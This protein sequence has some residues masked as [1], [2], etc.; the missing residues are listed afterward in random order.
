MNQ[1][2]I[3]EYID[4]GKFVST[5]CIQDKGNR[6]LLLTP[7]NR[8]VNIPPKRAVLI[9]GPTVDV[10]R[11]R[12]DL[13]EK[14]RLSEEFR[15][16]LKERIDVQE[17]WEL[18]NDENES[19]NLKYLAQ[20]AFGEA[21]TEDHFSALVRALFEDRLYFKMKDGLFRPNSKERVDQIARQREEAALKEERL[22][23]GSVWLNAVWQDRKAEEPSCKKNIIDTLVQLALHGNESSDYKYGK[24]LLS[25]AGIS[26]V[27]NSKNLLVKIGIWTEDENLEILRSGIATSFT[28]EQVEESARM[29]SEKRS[30]EGCEDLRDLPVMT[31]DGPHTSDFDDALSFEMAGD[32]FEIGVHISDVAGIISQGSLLDRG[33]ADRGSSLYLPQRQIPMLPPNLSQDILSLKQGCD[34][35]AISLLTKFDK[36]G[37]LLSYRFVRSVVRVQRQLTYDKVNKELISESPF[38]EMYQL[39]RHL[40]QKRIDQGALNLSLPEA[41]VRFN[42]DASLNLELVDQNTPSRLI[43][44]EF[45]ILYNWLAARF[46]KEN[47]LP[48]LFRTQKETTEKL[49]PHETTYTYYV[50][51]QRRK[52]HPLYIDTT[53]N[54]HSGLGLDVY[55]QATSPIRRYLDIVIQRQISSFLMEKKPIY[56]DES[57]EEI[58]TSVEPVV[59]S[60]AMIRR[61]RTRYWILKF[62]GQHLGERYK[63]LVLNELKNKYRIVLEEC[64]LLAEIKR[65]D[66]VILG[67]RQEILVDVKKSDPW[68]DLLE[69][70]YADTSADYRRYGS[71]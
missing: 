3:I 22:R 17:L 19:F 18:T 25:K 41:E 51:Q 35:P 67:P 66:G 68:E 10:S 52:L 61:K 71:G 15:N 63:A 31:I 57:L 12:E 20:L 69:L 49:D 11:P 58:R 37:T 26:D 2:K 16:N 13:L 40:H 70:T 65:R 30:F 56:D 39:C 50:F 64:L 44:S 42:P 38:K 54:P 45:M 36:N 23:D 53:P 9:T 28:N 29:A 59:K 5:L 33:A 43:V 60:L 6:L 34:R 32:V 24:E 1:G 46:C 48:V 62:L 14:L 4:R 21:A 27:L 7:T 47:K 8:Q 55:I